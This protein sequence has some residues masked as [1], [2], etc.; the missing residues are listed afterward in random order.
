MFP[1][2]TPGYSKSLQTAAFIAAASG[3]EDEIDDFLGHKYVGIS[4]LRKLDQ[5]TVVRIR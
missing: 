4:I 3:E 5:R 1:R 2:Y